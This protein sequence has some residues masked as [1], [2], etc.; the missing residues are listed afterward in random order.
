M[1]AISFREAI[2]GFH[3]AG[4]SWGG[5]VAQVAAV[6]YPDRVGKMILSS[7]GLSGGKVVSLM[8]RLHLASVRRGDPSKVLGTFKAR[9]LGLLAGAEE[10]NSLWQALF[11]DLYERYMTFE[12]YVSLISTQI[13]YVDRY[14]AR[15]ARQGWNKPVLILTSKDETAGTAAWRS[16]LSRAYPTARLHLF[17]GGGHH[18]ALLH[19]DEYR[20]VVAEFLGESPDTRPE[21]PK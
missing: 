2:D 16:A 20:R 3:A 5:Q 18:P 17:E 15:V 11:D 6:K 7:T 10:S 19:A 21:L 12:D 4:S 1:E 9:A 13:D 8:L 14:A